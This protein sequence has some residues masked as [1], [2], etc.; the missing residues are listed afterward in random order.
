MPRL[1]KR[2]RAAAQY[3][4]DLQVRSRHPHGSF[5]TAGRWYP[6][7]EL[8]CCQAIRSPSRTWPHSLLLHCRTATHVATETNYSATLLRWAIGRI[9]DEEAQ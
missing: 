2:L 8:E 4:L 6:D 1:S 7:N 3:A 5:D 9:R